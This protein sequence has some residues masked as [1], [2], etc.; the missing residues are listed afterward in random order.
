MTLHPW[1]YPATAASLMTAGLV[2]STIWRRSLAKKWP[3]ILALA[4]CTAVQQT[5]FLL[6]GTH[7]MSYA[8]YFY[9]Y[10]TVQ[11]LAALAGL[12]VIHDV[13]RAL[14]LTE[15]T[16]AAIRATL[17]S[18]ALII[19][20]GCIALALKTDPH[21]GSA[22]SNFVLLL[23]HCVYVAW[24]VFAITLFVGV[25][26]IG[27][28]WTVLP[29][30]IGTGF[31]ALIGISI[32]CSFEQALHPHHGVARLWG[33]FND[34]AASF[35]YAYWSWSFRRAPSLTPTA[36]QTPAFRTQTVGA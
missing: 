19:T 17:A 6:H 33:C 5:A 24:A 12:A 23:N 7:H 8:A 31:L 35:I 25:G 29:L 36:S 34:I 3:S 9:A 21:S 20:A 1:N 32:A 15:Y 14:P 26:L 16:P 10:W 13:I 22:I 4:G 28:G 11:C 2:A 30:R 27:F 18:F